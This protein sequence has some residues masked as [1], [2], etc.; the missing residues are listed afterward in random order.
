M[1]RPLFYPG[2]TTIMRDT[3]RTRLEAKGWRV[4]STAEFLGLSPEESAFIELKLRLATDL[5][6]HRRQKRLTQWDL[7]RLVSSSQSRVA[8]ME[9]GDPTV[10]LDLLVRTLLALGVSSREIAQ[11]IAPRRAEELLRDAGAP[12]VPQRTRRGART[13]SSASKGTLKRSRAT[14][15]R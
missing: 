14:G 11:A 5:R 9:A 4:G 1:Q 3:K 2:E 10:S 6:A 7:A 8:K 15:K 13:P 12:S